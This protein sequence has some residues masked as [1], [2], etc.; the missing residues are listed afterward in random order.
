MSES[1]RPGAL[2]TGASSGIG[3]ELAKIFAREGHDVALVARSGDQLERLAGTLRSDFGIHADVVV[4]DLSRPDAP[5]GVRERLD[6][7]GF[8]TDTLVNN[9]GFGTVGPFWDADTGAQLDMVQVN[10]SALIHLTRL[11]LPAMVERGS[12]RVLNVAS[13]A[14]F[15]PGPLMSVYFATKSFVLSFSEA[16]SEELRGSGVTVTALCPGPTPTGFQKRA[17]MEKTPIGGHLV[18]GDVVKVARAGY[19]GAMRG[20]RIVIPGA[21][22]RVGSFLPRLFPRGLA[23]RIV[24]RMTEA[25]R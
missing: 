24:V 16:L 13:T 7:A 15:Q 5:D 20:K 2:I 8:R 4:A 11:L 22:N 9:A 19:R 18:S 10:V 3:Y 12:G 21:F 6:A 25:R 14:A 17:G 23:T 1:S